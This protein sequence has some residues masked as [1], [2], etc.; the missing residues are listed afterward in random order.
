MNPSELSLF[1][2]GIY[3]IAGLGIGLAS[4]PNKILPLFKMEKTNEPWVR[5]CGFLFILLGV[6]YIVASQ[7]NLTPFFWATVYGRYA[8]LPFFTVLALLKKTDPKSIAFA[9]VDAAGATW[10]LITLL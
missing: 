7:Y 9:L 5:T 4:V 10:T 6:Y 1:V 2:F 8:V 3:L